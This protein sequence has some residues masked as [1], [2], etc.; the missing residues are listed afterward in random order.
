MMFKHKSRWARIG[1][2]TVHIF[3][4]M[5]CSLSS[6]LGATPTPNLSLP[7]IAP[8]TPTPT[9]TSNM[10]EPEVK[11]SA[12]ASPCDGLSGELEVQVLVGPAEAVGLEPLAVGAIPFSVV[13]DGGSY[14]V[15]GGGA[16]SYQAV[17]EKEWGTYTVSFDMEGTIVGTCGSGEGSEELNLTVVMSGEQMVE[18]R[19]EGFQGDYPWAGTHEL[20]L[21]FPLEDGTRSEGEGWAFI[22]RLAE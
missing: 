15:Q 20:D 1:L 9:P 18:V 10:G 4:I 14:S 16:L 3:V 21:S 5:A 17:L 13:T 11:P 22:L 7:T 12:V 8:S 2:V 6:N 19:A